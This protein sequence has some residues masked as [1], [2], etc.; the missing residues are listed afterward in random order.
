MS[1]ITWVEPIV[2][3]SENGTALTN[4][5]TATSLLPASAKEILAAAF[6]K[7]LGRQFRVRA[8]GRISTVVTTPGTLTL[9]FRLGSVN[10]FTSG[11]MALNTVAKTNVT[12]EYEAVL[13]LRA[14][15]SGTSAAFLGIGKFSSEAVIGSPLPSAGGS[16]MLLLPASAPANGTGFDGTAAQQVDFYGT[17]SVANASNSIQLHQFELI[18]VN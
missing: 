5:T 1:D 13:S 16:G 4:S 18:A 8:A 2:C 10:V 9:D 7:K 6:F 11:A 3:A 15:G 12:W 14:I 17:W